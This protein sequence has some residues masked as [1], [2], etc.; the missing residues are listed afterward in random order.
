MIIEFVKQRVQRSATI[1]VLLLCSLP[2][3]AQQPSD[4]LALSDW[5]TT[6]IVGVLVGPEQSVERPNAHTPRMLREAD[7]SYR[8]EMRNPD[9]YKIGDLW[10]VQV[11][12]VIKGDGRVATGSLVDVFH[13]GHLS[14]TTAGHAYLL[15][16]HAPI[17][18]LNNADRAN[19][20][21]SLKGTIV[22][23]ED[24]GLD[25]AFDPSRAYGIALGPIASA[26]HPVVE[27]TAES[28]LQTEAIKDAVRMHGMPSVRI[29]APAAGAVITGTAALSAIASDDVGVLG[30]QFKVDSSN[31]GAEVTPKGLGAI[32]MAWDSAAV[33]D[34]AHTLA[35][36]A[37]DGAGNRA[38]ST[39]VPIIVDNAPPSLQL[40]ASPASLWPV[41]DRL[42]GV[43]ITVT[44]ADAVDPAPRVQLLSITCEERLPA[45]RIGLPE[46]GKSCTSAQ[47]I[48]GATPGED[49]RE[50]QLRATRLNARYVRIY[51]ITYSARDYAG[52]QSKT[53][54]LV[55]VAPPLAR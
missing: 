5:S 29:V 15:F 27:L 45:A 24:P 50:F 21:R 10:R 38:N 3:A 49:I 31:A 39:A 25:A 12:E 22:S 1:V 32:S 35:A 48:V 7:G 34:G 42:V 19:G 20:W 18:L 33:A 53:S 26:A 28:A 4:W 46:N 36:V 55:Q 44:A 52:N 16:L 6:V 23:G 14:G 17:E 11:V 30:V 43:S 47:D 40:S 8:V 54:V 9:E 2:A 13:Q 41:D 51:T 37:R